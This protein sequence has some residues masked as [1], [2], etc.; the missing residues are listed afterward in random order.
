MRKIL[1]KILLI[2][3]CGLAF[4]GNAQ[5][6]RIRQVHCKLSP[7]VLHNIQNALSFQV[8]FFATVF[9]ERAIHSFSARI[10]GTEKEYLRYARDSAKFNPVRINAIAFYDNDLKEMILHKEINE[11]SKTFSHELTHA[12]LHYYCKDAESWFHEGLA[13]FFEDIV[14]LD[15]TYY[16]DFSI[17][18]KINDTREYLKE[19]YSIES[20]IDSRNFYDD[21][22]NKNYTLAWAIFYYLYNAN[23]TL[24]KDLI[25]EACN[26]N[27]ESIDRIYP[28]GMDLL[29][30]DLRAFY[31]NDLSNLK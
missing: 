1:I 29:K 23:N 21:S 17:H 28:G 10:F 15:S 16:F 12:L 20:V 11:L 3:S 18:K 4:V 8:D 31:L 24:Q 14:F 25:K 26:L 22:S 2:I 7:E 30:I 27:K 13:E 9:K 5:E 19:G 6:L